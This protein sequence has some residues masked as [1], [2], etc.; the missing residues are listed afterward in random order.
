MKFRG[1]KIRGDLLL[2]LSENSG[3][4]VFAVILALGKFGDSKFGA[5]AKSDSYSLGVTTTTTTTTR[6]TPHHPSY[7][8]TI[9][10]QC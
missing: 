6:N 2:W 3:T 10:T 1:L 5:V 9:Y 4:F 7:D 8:V